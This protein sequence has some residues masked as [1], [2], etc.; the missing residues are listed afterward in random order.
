MK[1]RCD[2]KTQKGIIFFCCIR[3]LET[4][5]LGWSYFFSVDRSLRGETLR[6]AADEQQAQKCISVLKTDMAVPGHTGWM[7]ALLVG[8]GNAS[9]ERPFTA[10]GNI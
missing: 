3:V 5:L 4:L 10:K 6:A 1:G 2:V 9:C 8:N 7:P